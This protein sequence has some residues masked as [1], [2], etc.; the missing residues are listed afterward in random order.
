M[1]VIGLLERD[2]K[3]EIDLLTKDFQNKIDRQDDKIEA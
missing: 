3:F 1:F 2:H